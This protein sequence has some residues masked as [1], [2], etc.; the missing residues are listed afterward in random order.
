MKPW[1]R[2]VDV[3]YP[4]VRRSE[5]LL[6]FTMTTVPADGAKNGKGLFVD[7]L[8]PQLINSDEYAELDEYL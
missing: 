8:N 2:F 7:T 1:K 5:Q 6:N 3:L 4:P